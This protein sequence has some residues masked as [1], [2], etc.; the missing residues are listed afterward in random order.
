MIQCG[1]NEYGLPFVFVSAL[2]GTSTAG[3]MIARACCGLAAVAGLALV[4]GH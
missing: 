3:C 1:K 4:N 2:T